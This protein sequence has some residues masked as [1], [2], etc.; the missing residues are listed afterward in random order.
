MKAESRSLVLV[1]N[2]IQKQLPAQSEQIQVQES[3]IPD[4][5]IILYSKMIGD[6]AN[7]MP[8]VLLLL[9]IS[10]VLTLVQ[11]LAYSSLSLIIKLYKSAIIIYITQPMVI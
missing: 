11:T 8:M 1:K 5:S 4:K 6:A 9:S 3:M 10:F 7:A 2:T